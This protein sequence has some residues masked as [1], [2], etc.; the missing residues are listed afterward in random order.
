MPVRDVDVSAQLLGQRDGPQKR[1][2]FVVRCTGVEEDAHVP[3]GQRAQLLLEGREAGGGHAV[4]LADRREEVLVV[5]RAEPFERRRH[6][7]IGAN[8]E[9]ARL[10]R[11]GAFVA[12]RLI[13]NAG[14]RN[15]DR[16]EH[17]E[18]RA[19]GESHTSLYPQC[20]PLGFSR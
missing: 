11:V 2:L 8:G 5:L 15:K 4:L 10:E 6:D 13:G 12:Q 14:A 1:V 7:L 9:R 3:G 20:V 17:G 19:G 16:G 18:G